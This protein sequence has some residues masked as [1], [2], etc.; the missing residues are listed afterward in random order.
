MNFVRIIKNNYWVKK[1]RHPLRPRQ[2]QSHKPE[3]KTNS[4]KKPRIG[5]KKPPGA[6]LLYY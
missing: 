1:I 2:I 5:P 6:Y 3:V 4:K